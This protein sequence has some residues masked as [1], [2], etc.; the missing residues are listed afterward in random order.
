MTQ[1]SELV[2]EP[3]ASRAELAKLVSGHNLD[4]I[5]ADVSMEEAMVNEC[6]MPPRERIHNALLYNEHLKSCLM[7]GVHY[8]VPTT[9]KMFGLTTLN[10]SD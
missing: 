10:L 3:W 4:I 1:F 2:A 6:A 5:F 7:P 8:A 9:E